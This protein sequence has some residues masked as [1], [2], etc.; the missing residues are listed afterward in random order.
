MKLR[1]KLLF[2]LLAIFIFVVVPLVGAGAYWIRDAGLLPGTAVVYSDD[3]AAI[4]KMMVKVFH[5]IYGDRCSLCDDTSDED[6]IN[7]ATAAGYRVILS[8]GT[9]T[10]DGSITKAV[11]NVTLE[12]QGRGTVI[13][14]ANA[15]N[16]N[17]ITVGG[18]GW[19]IKNLKIDGNKANQSANVIHGIY[20]AGKTDGLIENIV[21]QNCGYAAESSNLC[22]E[23]ASDR[24]RIASSEFLSSIF[25]GIKLYDE[26]DHILI[27]NCVVKDSTASGIFIDDDV[28]DVLISNSYF[29]GNGYC[30][31]SVGEGLACY[32]IAITNCYFTGVTNGTGVRFKNSYYCSM[33]D[34]ISYQE[35]RGAIDCNNSHQ[36]SIAN[37]LI[38]NPTNYGISLEDGSTFISVV[39]NV[40]RDLGTTSTMSGVGLAQAEDV[41]INN[42][43][44]VE[45]RAGAAR[46]FYYGVSTGWGTAGSKRINI[47]NNIFNG[48]V[49]SGVASASPSDSDDW[50]ITDNTLVNI[51][52][53]VAVTAGNGTGSAVDWIIEGNRFDACTTPININIAGAIRTLIM[54][55][56]WQGCTNDLSSAAATTPRFMDNIDKDGNPWLVDDAGVTLKTWVKHDAQN[57]AVAT[58]PAGS[59][60]KSISLF[61]KEVW[62]ADGTDLLTVGY[63]AVVNSLVTSFD[64]AAGG[65]G[66]QD[67]SANMG[68]EAGYMAT[69][70]AIE[71]YYTSSDLTNLTTGESCVVIEVATCP[72]P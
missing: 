12:G 5:S 18:N 7:A 65:L 31:V 61:T 28:N 15:S 69:A 55:N 36:V 24:W 3:A 45:T 23:G 44:F 64:L 71:L 42:N 41:T 35:S 52:T 29:D 10:I 13:A 63:D 54:G 26:P 14:L 30:H 37:N 46:Y 6:Q 47:S 22:L 49:T 59:Y 48:M 8:E 4:D 1:S 40:F 2:T 16:C 53:G 67:L 32:G 27:T 72:A 38:Y 20:A 39:G 56:D 68:V 58:I 34:S 62:N 19:A 66:W 50:S 43:V 25:T 57:P 9:F 51:A 11:N 21:V 33:S 17:V 70:R 60:I